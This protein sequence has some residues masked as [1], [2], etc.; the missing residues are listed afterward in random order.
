MKKRRTIII[1]LLLVAALALG[2]GYA[3]MSGSIKINGD[4]VNKPHEVNLTFESTGDGNEKTE[5]AQSTGTGT[6]SDV[7]SITISTDKKLATFS[8]RN[9]S[10]KDE[11]VL[12]TLVVKNNNEYDVKLES[13][14]GFT[15]AL[16]TGVPEFFTVQTTWIEKID[17]NTH[18]DDLV[19]QKGETRVLEVK[20]IM[21][22]STANQ[23]DGDFVINVTGTSA[24]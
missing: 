6:G 13:N 12:A 20:V 2:V 8:I 16:E 15:Y 3:G 23:Y 9:L 10:H 22:N 21:V 14:P 4:V 1:S 24:T 17:P 7:S 5:I 11:Y 18:T 19:L